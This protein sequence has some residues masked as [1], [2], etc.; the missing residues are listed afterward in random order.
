MLLKDVL[1]RRSPWDV[2]LVGEDV[3]EGWVDVG[4]GRLDVGDGMFGGDAGDIGNGNADR[5]RWNAFNPNAVR[6]GADMTGCHGF[7]SSMSSKMSVKEGAAIGVG[8]ETWFLNQLEDKTA[9]FLHNIVGKSK[10]SACNMCK[11]PSVEI[12]RLQNAFKF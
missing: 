3:D 10:C 12:I 8:E 4:D 2:L 5:G 6:K 7:S 9:T 1:L 11:R